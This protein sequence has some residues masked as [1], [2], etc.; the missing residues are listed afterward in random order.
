M[1]LP[2]FLVVAGLAMASSLASADPVDIALSNDVPAGK[3]PTL[4]LTA[5]AM[6][7]TVTLDIERLDDHKTF[8]YVAGPLRPGTR[9]EFSVGDGKS[10]HAHWKGK[11]VM[12]GAWGESSN[13]VTFESTVGG[14]G[15]A[16]KVTYDRAHLDLEKGV[17]Q[18]Q[19]SRPITTAK[20]TVLTEDGKS[21][22]QTADV[23]GSA[24]GRWLSISW[25]PTSQPV[26]RL[27]LDVS[28]DGGDTTE[29]RLV[30]WSVAI[31]HEEV[32]FASGQSGIDAKETP[33]LESSY[34]KIIAAVEKVR[35]LEP[36]LDVRVYV[37]GH[38]DT[39]GNNDDNRKL[40]QARARAI[41]S[42]FQE[43][44]LPLPLFFAGF[45]ED[46]PKVKT[47]DNVDEARNRR[48]D[49]VVGVE[50]PASGRGKFV[51]LR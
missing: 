48:V 8:H 31:S 24:P 22:E 39:V 51:V 32:V 25:K 33:K 30:P 47:A 34:D 49:Y 20:L 19:V 14:G 46:Q 36:T 29:V 21:I 38:T 23:S 15:V 9:K 16:P 18:F 41:A 42:W 43:R 10:G 7:A 13:E 44:G 40:S 27:A 5:K 2:Q 35:K 6:V 28:T 26:V 12:K 1:R 3:K 50:E 45:G 17:L 11:L 4:T 37:A